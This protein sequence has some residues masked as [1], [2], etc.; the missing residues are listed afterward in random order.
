M[1][2]GDKDMSKTTTAT[3]ANPFQ[4][5]AS[6]VPAPAPR[7]STSSAGT[8]APRQP[9]AP[10][11]PAHESQ[12]RHLVESALKETE[13][14]ADLKMG[15]ATTQITNLKGQIAP[16]I[17]LLGALVQTLKAHYPD[18][19]ATVLRVGF[20]TFGGER[21]T[22]PTAETY[23]VR[24]VA[25]VYESR[26]IAHKELAMSSHYPGMAALRACLRTLP[27]H[28]LCASKAAE[29]ETNAS[30][31]TV[32]AMG[33]SGHARSG[34]REETGNGPLLDYSTLESWPLMS[35]WKFDK[36]TQSL[37]SGPRSRPVAPES[38][39][40]TKQTAKAK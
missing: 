35:A 24:L 25:P 26:G 11:K 22:M 13:K 14:C 39:K 15:Y 1:T 37:E 28:L 8:K 40:T 20:F 32:W 16:L 34:I 7:A 5:L 19:L 31:L 21:T 33:N 23:E 38:P 30:P 29:E 10:I 18:T 3:P 12:I 6:R 9:K 2:E 4:E 36:E 27:A 17:T